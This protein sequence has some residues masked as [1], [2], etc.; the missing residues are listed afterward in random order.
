MGYL[1]SADKI[2][3]G[4][5]AGAPDKNAAVV[6]NWWSRMVGFKQVISTGEYIDSG[7]GGELS[8]LGALDDGA[9]ASEMLALISHYEPAAGA[10]V[11][12]TLPCRE[13][14]V[15]L[16]GIPWSSWTYTQYANLAPATLS[17]VDW[18]SGTGSS[19]T[20]N[21][22]MHG[23]AF[24]TLRV[25][26]GNVPEGA[27]HEGYPLDVTY[28]SSVRATID[29]NACAP[30]PP[31]APPPSTPSPSSS[32]SSLGSAAVVG[33]AIGAAVGSG[34]LLLGGVVLLKKRRRSH[35]PADELNLDKIKAA[36]SSHTKQAWS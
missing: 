33:V 4:D 32:S 15:Q 16:T 19:A 22:H 34:A 14:K 36:D 20:L 23:N 13:L 21:L 26:P 27:A 30:R 3:D 31:P 2:W 24:T 12:D 1:Y 6:L 7:T 5:V 25:A 11:P 10:G 17:A 9:S 35:A 8:V 29:A 28:S 18:G